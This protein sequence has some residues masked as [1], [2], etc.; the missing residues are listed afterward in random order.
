MYLQLEPE[1]L[2]RALTK[3][4]HRQVGTAYY[5]IITYLSTYLSYQFIYYVNMSIQVLTVMWTTYII[6]P[7]QYL[8][9]VSKLLT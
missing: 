3:S 4:V 2:K 8:L 7:T 9:V 6:I 1:S 5:Y